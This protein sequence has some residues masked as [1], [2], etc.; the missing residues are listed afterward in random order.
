VSQGVMETL[1]DQDLVAIE[2]RLS[3]APITNI[4]GPDERGWYPF[5]DPLHADAQRLLAE[6]RA[7][8]AVHYDEVLEDIGQLLEALGKPN[9]A[10]PVSPQAVMRECIED[11]RRLRGQQ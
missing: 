7:L 4:S 10:R 8:R 3:R 2:D 5:A 11:V 9:V 1:T 6:V